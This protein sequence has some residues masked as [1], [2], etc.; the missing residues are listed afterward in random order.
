MKTLE[1]NIRSFGWVLSLAIIALWALWAPQSYGPIMK[2][3]H[4]HCMDWPFAKKLTLIGRQEAQ[5]KLH[6]F[7]NNREADAKKL[8]KN[9]RAKN[10][11][12]D[13]R[14]LN[15]LE[16]KLGVQVDGLA[17][18]ELSHDAF[19]SSLQRKDQTEINRESDKYLRWQREE[20]MG[21]KPAREELQTITLSQFLHWLL[22]FYLRS[23]IL[24]LG[25]FLLRMVHRRG[26]VETILAGKLKIL[27]AIIFWPV[28]VSRYPHNVV[29]EIVVEAELRRLGRLFRR[30]KPSERSKVQKIANNSQEFS[31]WKVAFMATN[32]HRFQRGLLIALLATVLLNL[33]GGCFAAS[34][35]S[36]H[37]KQGK[38]QQTLTCLERGPTQF[39]IED[40]HTVCGSVSETDWTLP[41]VLGSLKSWV[42][43]KIV[44]VFRSVLLQ[45]P[46][47]SD[48][49]LTL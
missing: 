2:S 41:R 35:R 45:P 20:F 27:L 23:M 6:R 29:R 10:Y 34:E 48:S 18:T 36:A 13:L 9:Y 28:M 21:E 40:D 33:I 37:N 25:L 17:M 15:L 3:S 1:R 7:V 43:Q 32:R 46:A 44:P 26:V 39:Q 19:V 22:T 42:E 12:T 4:D 38:S 14:Q 11:F 49:L 31:A 47:V 8:G 5:A 24:V 30:L 16:K